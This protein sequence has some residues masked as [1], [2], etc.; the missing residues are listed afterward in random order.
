MALDRQSI[1]KRDFPIGRRGYEPVAVDEHLAAIAREVEALQRAKAAE[2]APAAEAPAPTAR[3]AAD[4]LATFASAQ[5][6]A[7]VE[8]AEAS[9]AAI[10]SEA[11][12]QAAQTAKEAAAD[13]RRTRDD[14][15]AR[16]QD[17]VGKVHEATSV[18]LERV[19]AMEVELGNVLESLRAGA[20]QLNGE[21]TLLAGNMDELYDAAGRAAAAPPPEA[22]PIVEDVAILEEVEVEEVEAD[23]D[24]AGE[25]VDPSDV[26]AARLVALNMA[27]N[28]QTREQTDRYLKANFELSDRDALLEEVYESVEG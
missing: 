2:P 11:R 6:Q 17:H 28:G 12:D 13:A 1:E 19:D 22:T 7:I 5:V 4:S 25:P 26:D 14:A 9:A 24:G 8:A 3:G 27:L 15:V 21:L 23:D 10:E 16:S 20:N 18:M